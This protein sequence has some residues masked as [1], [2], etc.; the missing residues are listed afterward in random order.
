MTIKTE[1][2]FDSAR[3]TRIGQRHGLRAVKVQA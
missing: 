1:A 2:G 3:D